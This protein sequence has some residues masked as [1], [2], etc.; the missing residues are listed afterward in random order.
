MGYEAIKRGFS[1]S[2]HQTHSESFR[3]RTARIQSRRSLRDNTLSIR[4]GKHNTHIQPLPCGMAGGLWR[5]AVG[6]RS[7]RPAHPPRQ[8]HRHNRGKLPTAV[9]KKA[10]PT[11]ARHGFANPLK[12]NLSSDSRA[13]LV[14]HMTRPWVVHIRATVD[15]ANSV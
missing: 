6:L 10:G 3:S 1:V 7:P 9:Q 8:S 5:F 13:F 11:P 2:S 12:P 14:V 4:E 15:M